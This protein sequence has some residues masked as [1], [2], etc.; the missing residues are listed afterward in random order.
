[1][2]VVVI[3]NGQWLSNLTLHR[4]QLIIVPTHVYISGNLLKIRVKYKSTIKMLESN[5]QLLFWYIQARIHSM[6]GL[7]NKNLNLLKLKQWKDKNV[8]SIINHY[9]IV[10]VKHFSIQ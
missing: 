5:L 8:N 9:I 2:A 3:G 7:S 10:N 4:E 6:Y 1:M